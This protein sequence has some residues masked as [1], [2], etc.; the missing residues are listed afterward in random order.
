MTIRRPSDGWR[1]LTTAAVNGQA[2]LLRV[3]L[4]SGDRFDP[5]DD[6]KALLFA[7]KFRNTETASI[8]ID[9]GA[10]VDLADDEGV[11]LLMWACRKSDAA[12]VQALIQLP[13]TRMAARRSMSPGQRGD[14]RSSRH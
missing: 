13:T 3:L 12:S 6:W 1:P 14:R 10:P 5:V 9:A 7:V 4:D 11:T 2:A 8:L